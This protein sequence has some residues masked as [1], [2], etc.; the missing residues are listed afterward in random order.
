MFIRTRR[1]LTLILFIGVL[2]SDLLS[3]EHEPVS[4]LFFYEA[5]CPHCARIDKFLQ[6]RIKSIY[7]V[8]IQYH[9]VHDPQ[10]AIL[11]SRLADFY[12]V[13]MKTPVVLIGD[14]LVAG[15]KR[16]SIIDMEAAVRKALRE[17]NGSPL[18]LINSEKD[19]KL[20]VTVPAVLAAAAVDAVNPCAFAVL[21]LLLGTIL[22][23]RKSKKQVIS[24]GLAFS[25]SIFIS[26]LLLGLGLYVVIQFTEIQYYIYVGVAV[27]SILI[28]IINI[29]DFFW[30]GKGLTL[31]VP[32]AWHP[33]I[34][35]ITSG[36]TS[37]PGAFI[38]G[39]AISIF[40]LPCSSGP[41]IVVIGMLSNIV[42]RMR[43][44]ALL[45]LYN[46]IFIIPFV[47]ITLAVGYG[48]ATTARVEKLRQSKVRK[49]HLMTGIIMLLIG[50]TL[51][52]IVATGNV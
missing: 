39:F 26:Y 19:L 50:I 40:L 25:C 11:L 29:K 27:L 18:K 38:I 12:N 44:V 13:E 8:E 47:L 32:R 9:E 33:K 45:L 21:T 3:Q 42:F 7:S 16:E 20:T 34:K 1:I 43:A 24:A 17:N 23:A 49:M 15:D 2:F 46:L 41:Y 14:T 5:G 51:I 35:K 36:V 37:V 10:N 48:L 30:Y 6:E 4:L 52:I 31:E 28:G 22:V